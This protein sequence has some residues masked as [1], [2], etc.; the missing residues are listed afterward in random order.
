MMI[1]AVMALSIERDSP[2]ILLPVEALAPAH[3]SF[4]QPLNRVGASSVY[5]TVCWMFL[6]PR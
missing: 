5:L 2:P 3:Q 6:C 4:H 1:C